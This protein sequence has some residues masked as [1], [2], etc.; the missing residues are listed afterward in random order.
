MTTLIRQDIRG[1]S[2]IH[3]QKTTTIEYKCNEVKKGFF[4]Y[5]LKSE[6]NINSRLILGK[7]WDAAIHQL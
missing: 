3:T 2:E 1:F 6:Y 5:L 7:K 4:P